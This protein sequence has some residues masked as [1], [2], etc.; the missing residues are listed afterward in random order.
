VRDPGGRERIEGP[1]PTTTAAA[2]TAPSPGGRWAVGLATALGAGGLW[3]VSGV[4][5]RVLLWTV[6]GLPYQLIDL[7]VPAALDFNLR[8]GEA[9][10]SVLAVAAA[11]LVAVVT[12]GIAHLAARALPPGAGSFPLFLGVWFAAVVAST[13]GA[14]VQVMDGFFIAWNPAALADTVNGLIPYLTGGG[15]WGLTLGW[16]VALVGVV[17]HRR[18]RPAAA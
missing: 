4:L 5:N 12:G 18:R 10:V 11:V 15:Y 16:I 7:V 8:P 6:D 1:S 13:I 9:Q 17:V 14:T 3:I 2:T